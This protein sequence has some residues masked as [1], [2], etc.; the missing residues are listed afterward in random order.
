MNTVKAQEDQ[1][2]TNE[3]PRSERL[4]VENEDEATSH[5]KE[6]TSADN[7]ETYEYL[8]ESTTEAKTG[9]GCNLPQSQR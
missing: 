6:S 3:A 1:D 8:T 2:A 5:W 9:N 7:D 4:D